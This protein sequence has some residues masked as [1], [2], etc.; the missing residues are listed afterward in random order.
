VLPSACQKVGD[1]VAEVVPSAGKDILTAISTAIPAL[2]DPIAQIVAV[3]QGNVSSVSSVLEQ[4]S[5]QI[6]AATLPTLA[7]STAGAPMLAPVTVG[8]PFVPVPA[9]HNNIDPGSGGDVP[10]GGRNYAAP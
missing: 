2:K 3:S 1:A 9:S 5:S 8:P 6:P 10:P 7:Q 4:I